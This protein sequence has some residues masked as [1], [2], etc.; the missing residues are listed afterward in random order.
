MKYKLAIITALASIA[1]SAL[2]LQARPSEAEMNARS[3]SVGYIAAMKCFLNKGLIDQA[4]GD[5]LVVQF[6]T[7]EPQNKPGVVWVQTT[8]AGI[9]AVQALLPHFKPDCKSLTDGPRKIG[10]VL[11]PYI[12]Q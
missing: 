1:C 10:E 12:V 5:R 6:V 7:E 9:A 11:Y 3:E 8:T 4:T 2:P